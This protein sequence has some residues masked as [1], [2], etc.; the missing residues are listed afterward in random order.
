[1]AQNL[2]ELYTLGLNIKR[3]VLKPEDIEDARKEIYGDGYEGKD[4][5]EIINELIC[6]MV[7]HLQIEKTKPTFEG[8]ISTQ[9][10]INAWEKDTNSNVQGDITKA[11]LYE[12]LPLVKENLEYQKNSMKQ[13]EQIQS[14]SQEKSM[15]KQMV[16]D[17]RSQSFKVITKVDPSKRSPEMQRMID[18][19]KAQM[20]KR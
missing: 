7:R 13:K 6:F 17:I 9:E 18:E 15:Y 3:D 14:S 20:R 2:S 10:F 4:A 12:V 11:V 5:S 8:K 16:E 1:M 19:A